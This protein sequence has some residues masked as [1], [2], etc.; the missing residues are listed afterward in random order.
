MNE[1]PEVSA[2]EVCARNGALL[3]WALRSLDTHSGEGTDERV[4]RGSDAL[5]RELR[6][7]RSKIFRE[8]E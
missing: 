3:K 4:Q 1:N 2:K 8:S 7:I 6:E 5:E